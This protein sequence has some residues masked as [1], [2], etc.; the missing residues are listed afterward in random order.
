MRSSC[1]LFGSSWK[2]E[3]QGGLNVDSPRRSIPCTKRASNGSI[4]RDFVKENI[5][6]LDSKQGTAP[7][8]VS[9][10][11][12][13]CS[14]LQK[15]CLSAAMVWYNFVVSASVR[16]ARSSSSTLQTSVKTLRFANRRR[17]A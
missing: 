5:L 11:P 6:N 2:A 7:E 17:V 13:P 3:P 14:K 16:F 12:G 1:A 4:G 9:M 8:V 15:M 10:W